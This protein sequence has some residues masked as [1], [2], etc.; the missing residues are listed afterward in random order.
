MNK[1]KQYYHAFMDSEVK[2]ADGSDIDIDWYTCDVVTTILDIPGVR[3]AVL[4]AALDLDTKGGGYVNTKT[5]CE[6]LG[7]VPFQFVW[8]VL[9]N[10]EEIGYG[11][12]T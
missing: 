8:D 6:R 2:D 3:K 10:P 4:G 9:M 5:N 12:E 11:T 7:D 1:I